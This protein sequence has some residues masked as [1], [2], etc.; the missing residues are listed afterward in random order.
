[1]PAIRKPVRYFINKA[2]EYGA[3]R[4]NLQ[5]TLTFTGLKLDSFRWITHAVR[6]EILLNCIKDKQKFNAIAGNAP[7]NKL[8][9]GLISRF[10]ALNDFEKVGG[11]QFFAVT[12]YSNKYQSSNETAEFIK[13]I[14]ALGITPKFIVDSKN[15]FDNRK[16]FFNV[17]SFITDNDLNRRYGDLKLDFK[18]KISTVNAFVTML[19]PNFTNGNETVVS[20]GLDDYS[21]H[22]RFKHVFT[23]MKKSSFDCSPFAI[24]MTRVLSGLEN[25]KMA[26]KSGEK[27][28][29]LSDSKED[30]IRKLSK[31]NPKNLPK[32]S[33]SIYYQYLDSVSA[34][35]PIIEEVSKLYEKGD[36]QSCKEILADRLFVFLKEYQKKR[37][38]IGKKRIH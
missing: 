24:T 4:I 23:R 6:S 38:K 10:L 27:A 19:I 26:K 13:D 17:S 16:H 30:V 36:L 12:D 14:L 20:T 35:K 37:E 18:Q 29:Y 1:M 32:F 7:S 11:E 33:E 9:I 8:H 31:Y 34:E 15:N 25:Y 3:K 28:I 2:E 22:S 5:D 21:F